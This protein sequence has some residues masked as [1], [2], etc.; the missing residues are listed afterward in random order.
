MEEFVSSFTNKIDAKGRVSVPASFR[1]V[2]VKEVSDE[3]FVIRR[4]IA[5]RWTRVDHGW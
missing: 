1:A 2:L 4:L 5:R 3:I